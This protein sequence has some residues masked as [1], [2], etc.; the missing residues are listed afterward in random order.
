MDGNIVVENKTSERNGDEIEQNLVIKD[1][2]LWSAKTPLPI[3]CRIEAIL[4]K[5]VERY[6][7][8][9]ALELGKLNTLH[10]RV[11]N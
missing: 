1:P 5:C 2:K 8:L 7:G 11:L 3:L 4:R 6:R 9:C 10:L